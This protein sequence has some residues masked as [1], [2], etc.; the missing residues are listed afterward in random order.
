MGPEKYIVFL[1]LDRTITS[2]NSG[3][4]LVRTARSKKLIGLIDIGNAVFLSFIYKMRLLPDEK[5]I[6]LMGRWLRGIKP[7]FLSVVAAEAS[8]KFLIGSVYKEVYE[9]IILHKTNNAELAILSSAVTDIC[10][11]LARH[12][13]IDHIICTDMEIKNGELTGFPD[14]NYCFGE[15]KKRLIIAFCEGRGFERSQAFYY[16]DSYSDLHALETVGNPV[17]IN[18]D[19]RLRKEAVKRNWQIKKWKTQ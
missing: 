12:L 19:R 7:Q 6:I 14:G 11:P 4:A 8:E 9:E 18:P 3:Y 13:G 5:I 17:C 15:E 1:D 10:K 2:I 16:A